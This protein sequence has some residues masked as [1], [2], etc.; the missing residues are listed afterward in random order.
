MQSSKVTVHLNI[1]AENIAALREKLSP[2]CQIMFVVKSDAY[3]HGIGPVA[4][5]AAE[6]GVNWFAV[7]YLEEALEVREAAPEAEILVLGPVSGEEIPGCIHHRITPVIVG[8]D[9]ARELS[10]AA[11]GHTLNAHIKVDTGMGRLGIVE[12][13]ADDELDTIFGQSNLHITGI[14]SHLAAVDLKRPWLQEKQHERFVNAYTRAEKIAGRRLLRH[15]CSSRGVQYY[16][17]WDHDLVRPGILLYGYGCTDPRMRVQTRPFLTMTS[18]LMQVKDVP[19]AY[20]I[21]Y[22]SSYRTTR[23][24]Q[25]GVVGM[26]Y[27]DGYLRAM[28]NRGEALVKGQRTS[29]VGRISMNWITLDLGPDTGCKAGDEVVLIGEQGGESIWADR[30]GRQAGT[31]AYEILTAIHPRIPRVYAG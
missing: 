28:S 21:G 15:F 1:L 20:P 3:G 26:G 11:A 19:E 6:V 31:I 22:Y 16:P 7:A 13:C 4:R 24:T 2:D 10:E 30:L 27:A 9:H 12:G 17:E 18:R 23:D 25:I 14:C 8:A 5:R 29:V